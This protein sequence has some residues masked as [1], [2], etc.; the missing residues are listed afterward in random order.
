MLI[1]TRQCGK[2]TLAQQVAASI[3]IKAHYISADSPTPLTPT[4]LEQ[5]WEVARLLSKKSSKG[6]LLI[7]DEIQKIH[8]WPEVVKKLWDE[9]KANKINL[10]VMILGSSPLLIQ[11]GLTET[12]AGRFE[13]I[14][15]YHWSYKEMKE[16][17]GWDLDKYIYFGGYPGSA[18]LI[19]DEERWANYI[20]D[21]LIETAVSRLQELISSLYSANY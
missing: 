10:K 11:K 5:Q 19:N 21:S 1:G 7:L 2:T 4:W 6:A 16:A 12:L 3:K 13:L 17:F 8:G 15:L 9:D 20:R 14:P 18:K